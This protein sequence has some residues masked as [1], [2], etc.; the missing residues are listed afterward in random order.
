[1]PVLQ[2]S[3]EG[4]RLRDRL[5]EHAGKDCSDTLRSKTPPQALLDLLAYRSLIVAK[6]ALRNKTIVTTDELAAHTTADLATSSLS[7]FFPAHDK[8]QEPPGQ[9]EEQQPPLPTPPPTPAWGIWTR[10]KSTVYDVTGE[11]RATLAPGRGQS[12]RRN[13]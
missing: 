11:R 6:Y 3:P 2:R 8:A 10:V 1:M 7:K 5:G 4:R 9:Q 12:S 13:S